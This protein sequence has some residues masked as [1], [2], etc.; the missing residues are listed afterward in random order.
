MILN[1][2]TAHASL[3]IRNSNPK[4]K[5]KNI[6]I[7]N[8]LSISVLALMNGQMPRIAALVI[9][10]KSDNLQ[11]R[12]QLNPN[13]LAPEC[14]M[15]NWTKM[16]CLYI[17][18]FVANSKFVAILICTFWTFFFCNNCLLLCSIFSFFCAIFFFL[19]CIFVAKL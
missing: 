14:Q 17:R 9:F 1:L 18:Y 2:L 11:S 13:F 10:C 16:T 15:F 3:L 19:F 12:W 7:Q 6:A 8:L 5:H 4:F